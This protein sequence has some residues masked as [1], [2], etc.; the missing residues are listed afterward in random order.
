MKLTKIFFALIALTAFC[1]LNTFAALTPAQKQDVIT[2]INSKAKSVKSMSATF[3]Q[4]KNLSMLNDKMVSQGKMYFKSPDKLRWEYTSPYQYQ[5]IFNG[6][7]VYVG[8]NSKKDVIDTNNNKMFKEIARIMM[9]TV[10]GK[11]LSNSTDFTVD[12]NMTGSGYQATLIPQ[13][14]TVKQMFSKIILVFSKTDYM[15]NEIN[16][17]EKNGDTT[18]I[19]FNNIS[20]NSAVNE[21]LFA[22][23]K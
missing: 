10:T 1:N 16:I 3:T 2:K 18:N 23:P 13:K 5:F 12:I 8:N 4:T 20:L 6:T 21:S 17:Y 11:A 7:K 19:K 14:K 9:N 22:I 15:V